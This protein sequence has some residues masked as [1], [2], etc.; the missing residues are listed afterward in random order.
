[1]W[2]KIAIAGAVGA[3]ILGTGTAALA[4]SG[5]SLANAANATATASAS[6]TG[7]GP[8]SKPGAKPGGKAA[9]KG[10]HGRRLGLQLRKLEHAEWVANGKN[11]DVTHDAVSGLVTAVSPTSISVK[12]SDG[13]TETFVVNSA[14]KVHVKGTN[15]A[16]S[17]VKTNDRVLVA[18]VKAGTTVTANQIVDAGPKK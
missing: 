13:F 8:S 7:A 3:A 4:E 6:P 11:G 1:M 18:G 16:I 2:K 15:K 12:A 5:G 14:S 17:A 10:G 9:A